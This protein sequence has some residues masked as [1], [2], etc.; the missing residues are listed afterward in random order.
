MRGVDGWRGKAPAVACPL[1]IESEL[2]RHR[3]R[4][5][6]AD[7]AVKTCMNA[8]S[9]VRVVAWAAVGGYDEA[10]FVDYVDHEFCFRCRQHG[11]G[12]VQ[13]SSAIMIHSPGEPQRHRL[14]WKHPVVSN[15]TALRRY[16]ITRN[17]IL[18]WRKY[19]RFDTTWV[20]RD[21]WRAFKVVVL[22]G[23]FESNRREKLAAIVYGV[24]DGLRGFGGKTRRERFVSE[25]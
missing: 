16:Y 22:T 8:G 3:P 13:V 12:V 4:V 7:V 21:V 9:I 11:W 25:R 23:L 14:L 24:I 10:F 18:F 15:H 20:L 19:L 6:A 5:P 1:T 17:Q 2:S